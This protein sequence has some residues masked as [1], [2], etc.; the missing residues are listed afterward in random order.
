MRPLSRA[1][2]RSGLGAM[3][4]QEMIQRLSGYWAERG[5]LIGVG[6]DV[7]KGAGTMNPLT[8]FRSLGPEPWRAAYVEPCRR[9]VDA[10]YGDNP[11]RLYRYFQFQVLLKPTPDDVV[12]QY[13]GSLEALGLDR[14]R[15][16][17]RFVEDNWEAATLGAWGNGWEVWL[18]GMEITQFT[19]FQQM[20]GLD[21]RP[22]SAEITYGLE[23][24]GSYLAGVDDVWSLEWAPGV[25]YRDLWGRPEYEHGRYVL[26]EADPD[27]LLRAFGDAEDQARRWLEAALVMPGYEF[28]L[29]ASNL[30]NELDARRAI[31]VSERQAYIGRLRTLARLAARQWLALRAAPEEV[32][33]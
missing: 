20:A 32:A 6:H 19:Y 23:R 8:F 16:D 33:P 29:K 5:C 4:M 27:Y 21:C 1:P 31:S 3:T 22:P 14:R 15:H 12:E 28:L 11:N 24:L 13:L 17:V 9:P 25:S 30:F 2:E 10:R 26:D 7:E 18:D